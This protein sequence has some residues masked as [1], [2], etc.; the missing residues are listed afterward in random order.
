VDALFEHAGVIR[1]DTVF[2]Q[3]DVAALLATQPLPGGRRVGI[4]SNGRGP[5]ISCADACTAAGLDPGPP[6]DLGASATAAEYATAIERTAADVDAL[7]AVFVPALATEAGDVASALRDAAVG[8]T[9]LLGAF[10]AHGDAELA[11]LASGSVPLYRSPV[12]AARALGRVARYARWRALPAEDPP[13]L[14][15]ADPDAAAAVIAA[16]LIRGEGWLHAEETEALLRAY[17]VPHGEAPPDGGVEMVAGVLGD[18]D[19]GPVVVCGLGGPTFE[20]LGD[21]AVRLAPLSRPDAAGLVRSLRSYPLLDGYRGA[22][23]T[24]VGALED[25]LVR[26][27]ALA[28]AHPEV[29]EVDCDP[30]LVSGGGAVVAGARVRVAPAGP[31][32]PFP[33][34]DR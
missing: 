19:F 21:A 31:A 3:L 8:D 10:M 30:V 18:P 4:V 28:E 13:E 32:R 22:P 16:A 25:V 1:T 26:L 17:G 20:L 24:D 12:E 5:A 15:G 7:V 23:P 34:L 33:A 29:V 9:T 11:A 6:L 2:E 27:S 14:E